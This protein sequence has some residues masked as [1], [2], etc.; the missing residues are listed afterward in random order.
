VANK[1][2]LQAL[3]VLAGKIDPSLQKAMKNAEKSTADLN[4]EAGLIGTTMSRGFDMAR[5]AAIVGTVAIG[6]ALAYVGKQGIALA[7]DLNEVQNVVDVTFGQNAKQIDDWAVKAKNQF[8]IS[9]LAAKQ[10]TGTIGAMLKSTGI[11]SKHLV[12]MSENLAGL[13]GDFSSFYNLPHDVA[14]DKI[15]AGISGETEPLKAIGINMSV[16][17]LEA[18]ALS[19]GIKTAYS[20][21]SEADKVIL[22][23]NYL[24]GASKDAQND[25]SRTSDSFSNQQRL[26]TTN[27][28]QLSAKIMSKTLPAFEKLFQK[29][30]LLM[31]KF[32][33]DK[34]KIESVSNTLGTVFDKVLS[35]IPSV[36]ASAQKF[37]HS[38][39]NIYTSS[40]QTFQFIRD[41]WGVIKPLI[42]GI[43]SAMIA[44]KTVTLGMAAYKGILAAIK[45]GT[46]AVTFAQKTLTIAKMKDAA[47]T[48]YLHALYA[49]D[50]IVKG[51]S[52]VAT[53]AMTA[54]TSAWTVATTIATAV[55]SAFAAVIAFI[56]S[57]IG[58]VIV[59][60]AALAAGIYFLIKYWDNVT[61]AMENAW[62]WFTA[63]I[64]KI[65]SLALV[66]TGPLAPLLLLIKHFDKLKE[67]AGGA[68]N[69]VKKFF[70]FGGNDKDTTG[71]TSMPKFAR[72][73]FANRPSIFGEAGPEAA[74]PLKRTPRSLSILNQ[75]ARIIGA[76]QN[77]RSGN[78]PTFVYAPN[79][80]GGNTMGTQVQKDFDDFKEMCEE[81]WESKRRE[82][83][84]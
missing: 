45:L 47:A 53:W 11:S 46:E 49:K 81:W 68:F 57:P 42:L 32:G 27:F 35:S 37:G 3:I 78:S 73:G 31:E 55:G 72:G 13:T 80:S 71:V 51:A 41:N 50:A 79:Y 28:Q 74:I 19:K 64:D 4:K 8:G 26:L 16:A 21:M 38:I 61:T 9:E 59:G 84:A 77:T 44:W 30:N 63:L 52:V 48:L 70:G 1:R 65:P 82:N 58:L 43:V 60:I 36:I 14:F 15:K 20:K 54:A 69:A 23:Y 62:Q 22:R 12:G 34:K 7:S 66:L 5:N 17:N 2:E 75:T 67:L 18:Y 76:D 6:A 29:A 10:F 25:F 40:V 24:L 33:N 56:T 39:M 83:F